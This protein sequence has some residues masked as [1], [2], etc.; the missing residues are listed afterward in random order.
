MTSLSIDS[1]H[2]LLV[3]DLRCCQIIHVEAVAKSKTI[4]R[5]VLWREDAQAWTQG[6]RHSN[7]D[8][9][10]LPLSTLF[11]RA[12]GSAYCIHCLF[13]RILDK[14]II[15]SISAIVINLLITWVS[16]HIHE[17]L[18]YTTRGHIHLALRRTEH[19]LLNCVQII[20]IK[21]LSIISM[22]GSI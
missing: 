5:K 1:E 13:T 14:C 20:I 12:I 11:T 22:M 10:L 18:C 6:A 16:L 17:R 3:L 8:S 9:T 21:I 7:W 4:S 2:L 15:L 19:V